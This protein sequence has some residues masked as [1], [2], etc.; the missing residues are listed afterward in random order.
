LFLRTIETTITILKK[1]YDNLKQE[2]TE[3]K[4]R[5]SETLSVI[6]ELQMVVEDLQT[7]I[8]LLKNGRNSNTSSTPSSQDY[9][10][11]KKNNLREKSGKKSGG[12]PGH[13][14]QTLKIVKILMR[15][16]DIFRDIVSTAEKHL[17]PTLFSN[18]IDANRKLLYLLFV[19]NI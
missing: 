13:K 9:S 1:E 3:L 7:E 6:S 19:Q 17:L 10:Y 14:G 5:L 18:C 11:Q 15:F 8:R 16:K 4:N 12:Q 2:N